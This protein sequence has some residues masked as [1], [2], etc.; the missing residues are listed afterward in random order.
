LLQFEKGLIAKYQFNSE[1]FKIDKMNFQLRDLLNYPLLSASSYENMLL[2]NVKD[3]RLVITTRVHLLQ[4]QK[5]HK[6][7]GIFI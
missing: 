7:I 5:K 1:D 4:Q 6:E 2:K 3:D